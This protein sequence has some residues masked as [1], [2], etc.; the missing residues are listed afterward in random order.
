MLD[1]LMN[2]NPGQVDPEET[3]EP[4]KNPI[5][6]KGDLWVLGRIGF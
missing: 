4:P 5:V 3:P 2:S 1:G 6:R